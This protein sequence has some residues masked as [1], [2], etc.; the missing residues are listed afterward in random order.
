[1]FSRLYENLKTIIKENYK[2]I[3]TLALCYA[4]LMFPV[5]YYITTGGGTINIKNRVQIEDQYESKGSLHLSYVSEL[6]GNVATYLFSFFMPDWQRI[7][8]SLYKVDE[9]ESSESVDFRNRLELQESIDSAVKVA[10]TRAKKEFHVKSE[11][12]YIIYVS[13]ENRKVL[14]V[15]DEILFVAGE[16]IEN[17]DALRKIIQEHDVGDRI[18]FRI[19]R[20]G[21]E[22]EVFAKVYLEEGQKII[23]ISAE[24]SYQYETDPKIHMSFRRS[25][26]G[27][28]GGMMLCLDIYNKLT[29]KD[30][31]K[32]YKIVG[33][34]TIAEDGSVGDIGGVTY[35]LMGAEGAKADIFLVPAG[36]NYKEAQK[37]AKKK[38]YKVKVIGVKNIE[39]VLEKL[40]ALPGKEGK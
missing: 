18:S 5:P 40:E 25:E 32:G 31:T 7:D 30:V 13:K 6:R 33:T 15:G 28:S 21:K 37:F 39:E 38:N 22:K 24:K 27:P 10:F 14:Q 9:E 11:K 20:D 23:G 16:K 2:S 29:K 17:T 4:V 36:D 12:I 35:K 3:I 8:S 1:M 26:S 19:K 34:G